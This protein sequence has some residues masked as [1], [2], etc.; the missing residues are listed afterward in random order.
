M[1]VPNDASLN[2]FEW[3]AEKALNTSIRVYEKGLLSSISLTLAQAKDVK[4]K[5]EDYKKKIEQLR[6]ALP[7]AEKLRLLA[8]WIDVK[9]P[10][11]SEPQVQKDLRA[12]AIAIDNVMEKT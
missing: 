8:T 9:Y 3:S 1:S 2:S 5:L 4:S 12:W 6:G 7:S 10:K 11:D